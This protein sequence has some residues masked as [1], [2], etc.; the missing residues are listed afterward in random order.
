MPG[1]WRDNGYVNNICL[2]SPLSLE[3]VHVENLDKYEIYNGPSNYDPSII[4]TP[5][6]NQ[7]E[8]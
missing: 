4:R 2:P 5:H 7:E 1:F 8:F 3:P 6:L